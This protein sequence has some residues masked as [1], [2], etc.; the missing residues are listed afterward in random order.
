MHAE[1][2]KL[3]DTPLQVPP[4]GE[5]LAV[6]VRGLVVE[7]G[8]VV[9]KGGMTLRQAIAKAGGVH[10]LGGLNNVA[11]Y[12]NAG[13]TIY[14]TLSEEFVD[15]PLFPGDMLVVGRPFDRNHWDVDPFAE[16]SPPSDPRKGPAIREQGDV[17]TPGAEAMREYREPPVERSVARGAV[18][19]SSSGSFP[20]TPASPS[21]FRRYS[22]PVV[23][24]SPPVADRGDVPVRPRMIEGAEPDVLLR[25]AER[26]ES[27][28]P[29]WKEFVAAI[30]G[31]GDPEAA[32]RQ[33]KGGRIYQESFYIEAARLLFAKQHTEL[34]R[35]VLSNLVELRPGDES[36][37]RA[38]AFWLAEFG[39]AGE[40]GVV[41][42][43]ISRARPGDGRL[44]LD[45]ASV[46]AASGGEGSA[47]D[48]LTPFFE[49]IESREGGELSAIMLTELNGLISPGQGHPLARYDETYRRNLSADIRIV[50]LSS[51]DGGSV[52]LEVEEPGGF[53]H[54]GFG[55]PSPC[56][57]RVSTTRGVSEYMIRH[58]VPGVYQISCETDHQAT[59]RVVIH[60]DWGR[61]GHKSRVETLTLDGGR[62]R[63]VG[64]VEFEFR[65]S[66][67]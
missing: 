28:V 32:Y 8:V 9:G 52:R 16:P 57:G 53:T 31:G 49:K 34:A 42:S 44:R 7:P 15:L 54:L 39:L 2:P 29:G 55:T 11:L 37:A 50:V 61:P 13:K 40:A 12:R 17:W 47:V 64:K 46:L 10:R 65:P 3:A 56:G 1:G 27:E 58:A 41:L 24:R 67:P 66:A 62:L 5:A 48:C 20:M 63:P 60:T 22:P 4:A 36:A 14:N 6:S 26:L 23:D 59:V 43:D 19:P 21:A 18:T 25:P 33:T 30:D 45:L 38:Y 51:D 35:R